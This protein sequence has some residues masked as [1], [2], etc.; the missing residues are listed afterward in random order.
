MPLRFPTPSPYCAAL[1]LF[2][3]GRAAAT[4]VAL[5]VSFERNCPPDVV[6]S[7]KAEV[8]RVM[9]GAGLRIQWVPYEKSTHKTFQQRL[10]VVR[11]RGG[12]EIPRD[13]MPGSRSPILGST[14]VSDG[15]ILPFVDVYCSRVARVLPIEIECQPFYARLVTLGR[16]LGRV[17]AHELFHVFG[18][19]QKHGSWG[20]AQRILSGP[21]LTE[22]SAW[23]E[24][25]DL[26]LIRRGLGTRSAVS[27]DSAKGTA[28]R[29]CLN[30]AG[31]VGSA[32]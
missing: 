1:L 9:K 5:A 15:A 31:A 6:K 22:P 10:V 13:R 28:S 26:E 24:K 18:R 4:E 11:F 16:A 7:L 2:V 25:P 27:V 19:T 14:H 32:R 3:V 17:V 29:K 20:L 8:Q 23:F 21:A 30:S 12:C